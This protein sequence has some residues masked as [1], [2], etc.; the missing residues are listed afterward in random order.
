MCRFGKSRPIGPKLLVQGEKKIGVQGRDLERDSGGGGAT[1]LPCST[2]GLVLRA[3]GPVSHA[4]TL[5][6][7]ADA[8]G[9]KRRK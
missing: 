1:A 2:L 6:K 8:G 3:L 9:A 5:A 4:R 7:A